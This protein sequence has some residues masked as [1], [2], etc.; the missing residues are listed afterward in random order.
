M[1]KTLF[2]KAVSVLMCMAMMFSLF[3]NIVKPSALS[4][5]A[6]PYGTPKIDG[7]EDDIWSGAS[8]KIAIDFV[9]EGEDTGVKGYARLMW[10]EQYLYVFG[11]VT[12][13]TPST[14]VVDETYW[15]TDCFEVFL[16]EENAHSTNRKYVAQF[17]VSRYGEF[18]GMLDGELCDATQML[19]E[20]KNAQWGV[21]NISNNEY[22]IEL[23]IPWTRVSDVKKGNM[24]G[25]EFAINDDTGNDG[26]A[27]CIVT[28]EV[29]YDQLWTS[30]VYRM[31]T[32][33]DD[34]SYSLGYKKI[35]SERVNNLNTKTAT[36]EEIESLNTM[37]NDLYM[38]G[39]IDQSVLNKF[40]FKTGDINF[41]GET[42]LLDF[43]IMRNKLL[44]INTLVISYDVNG[45]FYIDIRDLVRM[46]TIPR[47]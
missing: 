47:A 45:D 44:E 24:I 32:L 41:D 42:N 12:D 36:A 27:D 40:K 10:D 9:D 2:K 25:I 17:R 31:M 15:G 35:V 29:G 5:V 43:D 18:T 30:I 14:K 1:K 23:A 34:D 39:I 16:D 33:T 13:N 22:S 28:S 26:V 19:A 4:A 6:I 3:G 38:K 20:Y 8:N 7:V 11:S 46:A 21:S 37:I